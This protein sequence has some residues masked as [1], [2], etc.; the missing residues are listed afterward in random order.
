MTMVFISIVTEPALLYASKRSSSAACNSAPAGVPL[1]SFARHRREMLRRRRRAI[2]IAIATRS[3]AGGALSTSGIE[4]DPR[5]RAQSSSRSQSESEPKRDY[6]RDP[7]RRADPREERR[8]ERER[9]YAEFRAE[10]S[11]G[12]ERRSTWDEQPAS[13][14]ACY[15]EITARK[16]GIP[17]GIAGN[18]ACAADRGVARGVPRRARARRLAR[19]DREPTHGVKLELH[20]EQRQAWREFVTDH[21]HAGDDAAISA[22]CGLRYREQRVEREHDM[23][24]PDF[25]LRGAGDVE[26]RFMRDLRDVEARVERNGD[27]SYRWRAAARRF[28]TEGPK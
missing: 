6:Q 4:R 14:R 1:R 19:R 13:E 20:L 12:D 16:V 25:A 17:A 10:R 3:C 15:A 18:G 7:E 27:V 11:R 8:H 5:R 22:L 21:A 24:T 28:A 9:L 26:P 23:E 2:A